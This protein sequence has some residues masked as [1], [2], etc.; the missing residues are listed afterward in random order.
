MT[1][2]SRYFGKRNRL[3]ALLLCIAISFGAAIAQNAPTGCPSI[4]PAGTVSGAD[5]TIQCGGCLWLHADVTATATTANDYTVSQIQYNPPFSY[6]A[7][8]QISLNQDDYYAAIINLPFAFCFYGQ[9][10]RQA[11]VGANGWCRSMRATTDNTVHIATLQTCQY[12]MLD[13]RSLSSIQFTVFAKTSGRDTPQEEEGYSKGCWV[14]IPV[15]PH[16]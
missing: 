8:N 15:V 6:T 9:T 10:Y 1:S 3:L 13:F 4:H 11:C 5:T 7:G 14:H 16:V 12:P 2:D